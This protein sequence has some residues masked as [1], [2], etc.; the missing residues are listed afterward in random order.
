[1]VELLVDLGQE[2]TVEESRHIGRFGVH[3]AVKTEVQV[4][5]VEL[6]HLLQ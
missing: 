2:I 3:D 1:M 5:L 4:R 6:E